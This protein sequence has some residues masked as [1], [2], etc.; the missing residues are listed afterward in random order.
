MAGIGVDELS[1][2]LVELKSAGVFSHTRKGVIY[3]R[4]MVKDANRSE[5]GRK[6]V[7]KRWAQEHKNKDK[8]AIPNRS[9]NRTPTTQK[10]EARYFP[11]GKGDPPNLA[12]II[13]GEGLAYLVQTG[14]PERHARSQL[15]KWR[16][17]LGEG[18][19]VALLAHCQAKNISNPNEYFEGSVR[20]KRSPG[21][22]R[23]AWVRKQYGADA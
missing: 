20:N 1:A 4:R 10:P 19:V 9:P 2:L 6:A 3:S 13:F 18:E 17:A 5:K 15:G 8:N 16:K 14:M 12:E 23:Q 7:S 22:E 11:N 21:D